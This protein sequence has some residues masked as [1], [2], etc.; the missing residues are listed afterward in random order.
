MSFATRLSGLLKQHGPKLLRD[1]RA[2]F[3]LM[4]TGKWPERER[5]LMKAA[6]RAGVVERLLRSGEEAIQRQAYNILTGEFALSSDAAEETVRALCAAL[7]YKPP[8]PLAPR[9]RFTLPRLPLL[10]TARLGKVA[11]RL[12]MALLVLALLGLVAGWLMAR[13]DDTPT[14]LQFQQDLQVAEQQQKTLQRQ[15][16]E[17]LQPQIE[18]ATNDAG[19]KSKALQAKSPP[20]GPVGEVPGESRHETRHE[21]PPTPRAKEDGEDRRIL[22]SQAGNGEDTGYHPAGMNGFR[23]RYP[24]LAME[25]GWEGTVTLKVHISSN[26]EIGE[27]IMTGSSG[28]DI[29]DEAAVEMIKDAHATPALRGDKPVDSWVIVPY[30]FTISK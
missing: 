6:Y 21:V 2:L 8:P 16:N 3:A 20:P 22:K 30:R 24:R 18:Q 23:R 10:F 12:A 7:N 4:E 28:H 14:A 5:L 15:I 25:S 9:I 1:Q 13:L 11:S 26:G 19:N 17:A 29:L 27:V